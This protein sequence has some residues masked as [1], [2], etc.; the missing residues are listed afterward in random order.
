MDH[1]P[2]QLVVGENL[3]LDLPREGAGV[4]RS[5]PG[6]LLGQ[7][8]VI[9]HAGGHGYGIPMR[10]QIALLLLLQDQP[11][12]LVA[13][14]VGRGLGTAIALGAE[15]FGLQLVSSVCHE[16]VAQ[17]GGV[18]VLGISFLGK[19]QQALVSLDLRRELLNHQ[20]QLLDQIVPTLQ[21][22]DKLLAP[23]LQLPNF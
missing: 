13:A 5:A 17:H 16:R 19:G 9:D 15:T 21:F 7:P 18:S 6:C 22:F 1:V 3:G 14:P 12:P 10:R 2:G 20:L 23:L 4:K 11:L 8:L